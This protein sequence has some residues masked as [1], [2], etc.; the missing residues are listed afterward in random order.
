MYELELENAVSEIH[1]ACENRNGSRSPFFFIVG[2]GISA[3]T[4]P[5][6]SEIEAEC[7]AIAINQKRANEPKSKNPLDSY[8]HWFE[9]AWPNAEQRQQ[10]LR[11]KI[12]RRLISPA[13][14]R[15]AHLL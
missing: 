3:P 11:K 13:A 14:L 7:K 8:S 6:A 2:A 12:E 9:A 10:Y 4:I 5:I 15:L 1:Q